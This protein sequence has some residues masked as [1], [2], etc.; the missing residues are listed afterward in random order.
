M[1]KIILGIV[2]GI[3]VA[4]AA[5]MAGELAIHALTGGSAVDMNDP[6]AVEAMM[7]ATPIGSKIGIVATY[8]V[9]VLLGALAAVR[10]SGRN[11]TAWVIT[12]VI[13]AATIANYVMLPHPLWMVVCSILLI[14]TAGVLASGAFRPK[15]P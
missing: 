1:L 12:A 9:A 7:A 4:F 2:A 13:L 6:A 15:R 14:A 11:W 3:V 5:V 10:V 8:F